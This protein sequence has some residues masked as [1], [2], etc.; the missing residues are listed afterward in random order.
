[1]CQLQTL[2]H[3]VLW[4]G[5]RGAVPYLPLGQVTIGNWA[6]TASAHIS[7]TLVR[8]ALDLARGN[9]EVGG[10]GGIMI[11]GRSVVLMRYSWSDDGI[12]IEAD[13]ALEG[14]T[15]A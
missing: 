1:M 15:W 14:R 9:F 11:H 6:M 2:C 3:A 13:I 10:I 5:L 4:H 12:R 7:P 8:E